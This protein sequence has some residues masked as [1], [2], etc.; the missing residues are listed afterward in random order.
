MQKKINIGQM[1]KVEVQWNVRPVDYST[2]KADEIRSKMAIK[3]GIPKKNIYINA[4]FIKKNAD[5]KTEIATSDIVQN[6]QE[7]RFQQELFK[8]Y[9]TDNEITDYNFDVILN[10]D[11]T[12]NSL[13][14]YSV[15][16]KFR[17]YK[18][19]WVRW[20]NFLSYGESN[21]INFNELHGL[22]LLK[23]EPANQG[24]KTNFACDL[25]EFLL[26][27]SVDSGKANVLKKIFNKH[28]PDATE[29]KVEGGIEID[30][31]HYVIKRTLTRP[32]RK[33]RTA[34]S[35]VT[36]K[37]EYFRVVDGSEIIL[38]DCENLEEESNTKTNKIIKEAI[39]N[40][41][42]FNLVVL[43]NS[44]NLKELV[45]M[46]DTERGKLLSRWIGLLPLEEKDIKA[47][48]KWNKEILPSLLSSKYNKE[49]LKA[50]VE[51]A[52][53]DIE[54]LTN[55]IKLTEE[56]LKTSENNL[57]KYNKEKDELFGLKQYVDVSLNNLDVA[58][59]EQKLKVLTQDGKN[60]ASQ[61]ENVDKEINEIGNVEYHDNV[62][63]HYIEER[64]ILVETIAKIK[65]DIQII[66]SQIISLEKAEFCPTCGQKLANVD[67]T[68]LI[69]E[70][71]AK[72]QILYNN[73]VA[74]NQELEKIKSQISALE[75][76]RKK[77]QTKNTLELKKA[78]LNVS[79][80]NKRNEYSETK[81]L[82]SNLQHCKEA[83]EHN[84]KIDTKT[85]VLKTNIQTEESI[86]YRL[87][88]EIEGYKRE[89]EH[90]NKQISE[91]E[92][93][94]NKLNEE[95]VIVKSWK[96]YLMMVGKNGIGKMVL[97]RTL[98]IINSELNYLLED[99]CDF[100]VSV[101]IDDK[102]DIN[103]NI[104]TDDGV[105]SDLSSGSGF[106]Q[107]VA[108][109]ALRAVLGN[110]STM[111]RPSFMLLD[112]VLGGVARDNYENIKKLYDRMLKDYT[113]IFQVTHLDDIADWHDT[114][115]VVKKE[116]RV[117]TISVLK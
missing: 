29:V 73:G 2:E 105:K 103:F 23:S 8:Q 68:K 74:T 25:I 38:E 96:I 28:L 10:I 57:I 109:L 15:Y 117:S 34:K 35:V 6:I 83:I 45:S 56:K 89:I 21:F 61:I 82:L 11:N 78:T 46:K 92:I 81:N 51:G 44:D 104:I 98:P 26:F 75:E 87:V 1:S 54:T 88:G 40:K 60:L 58:T 102:N 107:T 80:A 3:Y 69:E 101:E 27:G 94:I 31:E 22:V 64:N 24:G 93:I 30:G 5:G 52:K 71:K 20:D 53:K 65:A 110:I 113:F 9:L 76:N 62:Y 17:R 7:P 55:A 47:R 14:D 111:S 100:K 86:K 19:E 91:H 37:V 18:V 112:E 33:K 85:N 12:L 84:N 116:N 41:K 97:R 70:N 13:M 115:V 90:L 79:I 72:E 67:N 66:R 106:E 95:E 43:A 42:D 36:Q 59:L 39:G 48:E 50:Y 99:V 49:E 63:Q 114:T 4:N 32:Q 77:Y 108:A 16:E